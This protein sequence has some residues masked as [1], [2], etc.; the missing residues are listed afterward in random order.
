MITLVYDKDIA[1]STANAIVN[2]SNGMGYMGGKWAIKERRRGVAESIQYISN[3]AV[4]KLAKAEC[5]KHSIFGY[6][7]GSIFVTSA[8]NMQADF[9]IHA[10]TMRTPGSK[11]KIKTIK[12]VVP[13]IV[14]ISEQMQFR[15]VAVPML[16]T[17]TGGLSPI[18]V[19]DIFAEY[20]TKS[21]VEFFI[22]KNR[23]TDKF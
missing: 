2:A 10:V 17:G 21:I 15:T 7:P 22:Y 4:E 3:G 11:A 14:E 1:I 6:P 18:D 9:I 13:Y 20:F 8:P 5:R 16:G 19:Y 23:V 12:K